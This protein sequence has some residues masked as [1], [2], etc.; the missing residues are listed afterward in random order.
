[1]NTD[2]YS[3]N[4]GPKPSKDDKSLSEMVLVFADDLEDC[5]MG[6]FDFEQNKWFI[7]G[8]FSMLLKCWC[9]IP[10][11][12]KSDVFNYVTIEHEGYVK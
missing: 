5:D 10:K 9:E 6:F 1:M 8:D 7:M 4:V 2:F 12:S 3:M 11:P